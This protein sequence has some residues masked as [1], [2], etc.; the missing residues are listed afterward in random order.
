M[1]AVLSVQILTG[2]SR[3]KSFIRDLNPRAAAAAFVTPFISA[4]P[5]DIDTL[6]CAAPALDEVLTDHDKTS[7]GG[8]PCPLTSRPVRVCVDIAAE[9]ILPFVLVP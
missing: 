2:Q 7:G 1:A 9:R 3:P 6:G 8:L 5:E 4:S